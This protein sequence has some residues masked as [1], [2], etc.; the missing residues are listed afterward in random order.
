MG[1][2]ERAPL[3]R[4]A[5]ACFECRIFSG[6]VV[7]H[8]GSVVLKDFVNYYCDD[9]VDV[10]NDG[11]TSAGDNPREAPKACSNYTTKGE[12]ERM[13][14]T[15]DELESI[16]LKTGE[17]MYEPQEPGP[18]D[19]CGRGCQECVWTQYWDSKV[20]YNNVVAISRGIQRERTPFEIFE[21]R[22]ARR[23]G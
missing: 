21:E 5:R 14:G 16:V 3:L 19:C 15:V 17:R 2:T 10:A 18:D 6:Y 9:T 22:L 4:L 11:T 20:E 8:H 7:R 13:T 1:L 12:G 23:K